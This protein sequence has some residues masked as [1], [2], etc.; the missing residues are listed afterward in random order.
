MWCSVSDNN[1]TCQGHVKGLE[2]LYSMY[3]Q[4]K[5]L[6]LHFVCEAA[7]CS[8][9]GGRAVSYGC[10]LRRLELSELSK[11]VSYGLLG[12]PSRREILLCSESQCYRLT[13]LDTRAKRLK[14]EPVAPACLLST[15]LSILQDAL[16]QTHTHIFRVYILFS[17]SNN[18]ALFHILVYRDTFQEAE[19]ERWLA[20]QPCCLRWAPVITGA[21]TSCIPAAVFISISTRQWQPSKLGLC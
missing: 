6:G 19:R 4:T 3:L 8:Q 10:L 9:Q 2:I 12:T 11:R 5:L 18:P 15:G 7:L 16:V 1:E 17:I 20:A 21:V 14:F 13:R